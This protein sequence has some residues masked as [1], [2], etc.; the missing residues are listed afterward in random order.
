[1]LCTSNHVRVY[2]E[3]MS[4]TPDELNP[5]LNPGENPPGSKTA[6]PSELHQ[7]AVE[8]EYHTAG[9]TRKQGE[10]KPTAYKKVANPT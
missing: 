4:Q 7:N 6:D 5:L 10:A 9:G 2:G 3:G 1:L 8:Q